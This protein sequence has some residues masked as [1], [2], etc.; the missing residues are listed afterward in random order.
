MKISVIIPTYKCTDGLK[1]LLASLT[2]NT[3]DFNWEIIVADNEGSSD[4]RA[5]VGSLSNACYVYEPSPGSYAARNAA[6]A[7]ASGDI[8]AF[9]DSDCWVTPD[10]LASIADAM[11]DVKVK[12]VGGPVCVEICG[13]RSSL[14][15]NLDSLFAFRVEQSIQHKGVTLTANLVVRREHFLRVGY[16][17]ALLKSGGDTEWCYRSKAIGFPVLLKRNIVVYHPPRN[18]FKEHSKKNKR[19]LAGLI[20]RTFVSLESFSLFAV[21]RSVLIPPVRRLYIVFRDDRFCLLMRLKM[22]F[23]LLY[24]WGEIC[25][26][27]I[28]MVVFSSYRKSF[29]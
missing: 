9:V 21:V 26:L 10:Y 28:P 17:N 16:F 12:V 3:V 25:I 27:F 8:L 13:S 4:V 22:S 19:V 2:S 24:L 14:W 29:R 5:L 11:K 6:V 20:D 15:A 18:T 7:L 1:K 23:G